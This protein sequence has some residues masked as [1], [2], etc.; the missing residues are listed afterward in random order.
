MHDA[1]GCCRWDGPSWP[2][3]TS[4]TLTGLAN[5]LIDYPSIGG[6]TIDRYEY[7]SLL[8]NYAAS[9]YRNGVP[10]VA[11]AHDPDNNNWMYDTYN[12]SEDYNH[13]TYIDNV[14][15]G[16]IGVRGQQDNTLLIQPL[17][18]PTWDYFALENLPYHG[19]DVTVLWDRLGTRYGQGIGMTVFVD[20][21]QAAHRLVLERVQVDVGDAITQS[22]DDLYNVAVNSQHTRDGPQPLASYVF[23]PVDNIWN[24]IDGIVY[25][26]G[27]PEN[28][29]WTTYHSPHPTDYYGVDLRAPLPVQEIRLTFYDDGHGVRVPARYTVQYWSAASWHS[30]VTA[31]SPPANAMV[32]YKLGEL[33]TSKVR[34]VAANVRKQ[35]WGL[36]ELQVMSRSPGFRGH[37]MC[38]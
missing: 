11:E 28:S 3:E 24:G 37:F 17:A 2:Y 22:G 35:G 19:H 20:N 21:K 33:S 5:L 14:I 29:R 13:S 23:S 6:T 1:S 16:L 32:S 38:R 27:I 7:V 34:V 25:R 10:Y 36:S 26:T 15:S 18:P 30:L 8:H 12:H 9:Q 4:Q 31:G